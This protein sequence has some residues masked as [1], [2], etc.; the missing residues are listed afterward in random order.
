MI[1]PK[2]DKHLKINPLLLKRAKK[3]LDAKTESE[4]VEKSLSFIISEDE[5]RKAIKS[6]K[7]IGGIEKVYD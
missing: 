2:V 7:G 6:V 3:I 1:K 5:I 4:T